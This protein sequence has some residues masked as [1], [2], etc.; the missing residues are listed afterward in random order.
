MQEMQEMWILDQEDPLEERMATHCSILAWRIPWTED[1]GRLQSI[2]S[3]RV[4]HDW[5]N[6][7]PVCTITCNTFL[8]FFPWTLVVA[9]CIYAYQYSVDYL[10]RILHITWVLFLC[11]CFFPG[12][13]LFKLVA[14]VFLD[15][16]IIS[17]QGVWLNPLHGLFSTPY[18][19]KYLT[20]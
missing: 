10:R 9:L 6:L 14:C 17:T 15:S 7:A 5:S 19:E 1:P 20:E 11:S 18:L 4:G 12:T 2:G 13:M 3:Q 8:W 16:Q